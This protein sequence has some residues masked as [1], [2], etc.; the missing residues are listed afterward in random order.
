MTQAAL[1][2]KAPKKEY[3]PAD[4]VW[5][6]GFPLPPS[7]KVRP[8]H[9]FLSVLR[10]IRNKEDT[11]QV[12]EIVQAMSGDSSK[13]LFKRFTDSDYGRRVVTEPVKLEAAPG[14]RE[15]AAHWLPDDLVFTVTVSFLGP[16][17]PQVVITRIAVR[18]D[19]HL[20]P[21]LL[22]QGPHHRQGRVRRRPPPQPRRRR[23]T[24]RR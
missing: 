8:L 7:E 9:A 15:A 22:E 21:R 11:R 10:L 12:F 17:D 19:H 6:N 18:H 14:S 2:E 13:R 3:D 23:R 1:A 5:I 20:A 24:F 4:Y 16:L